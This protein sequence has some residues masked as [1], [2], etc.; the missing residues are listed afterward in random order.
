MKKLLV[1]VFMIALLPMAGNS[2][3]LASEKQLVGEWNFNVPSAPYGYEKGTLTITEK[4][5]KLTGEVKFADGYKIQLK[6]VSFAE[7]VFKCGLYV[8]YEY[9]NLKAKIQ[10]QKMTG[11][12]M[13]SEGSMELSATKVK[14]KE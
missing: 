3:E 6:D 7:G 9:V 11:T 12:V 1:F 10:D 5:K 14:A 2:A 8:D 4:E 13:S